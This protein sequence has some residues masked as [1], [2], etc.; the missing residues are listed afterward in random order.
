MT[1]CIYDSLPGDRILVT[2]I[3]SGRMA[4]GRSLDGDR[5]SI[6]MIHSSRIVQAICFLLD[7]LDL[8]VILNL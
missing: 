6:T 3:H 2:M 5:I 8:S 4:C 7:L 1:D